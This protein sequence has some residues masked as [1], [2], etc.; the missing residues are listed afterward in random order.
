MSAYEGHMYHFIY[1]SIVI[2]LSVF[3]PIYFN[4][5]LSLICLKG[6]RHTRSLHNVNVRRVNCRILYYYRLLLAGHK[7]S[8][9]DK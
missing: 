4:I 1:F 9:R 2:N 7:I 3:R 8:L 6:V 5:T